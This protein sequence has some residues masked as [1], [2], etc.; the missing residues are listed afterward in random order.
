MA[1]NSN[2]SWTDHTWSPWRGCT[3][4]SAGC[5][6]CYA[7]ALAKRAGLPP[8][9]KGQPRTKTVPESWKK[10]LRWDKQ[11][12]K[13]KNNRGE[14]LTELRRNRG[15]VFV[16]NSNGSE[17][18]ITISGWDSLPQ[19]RPKVFFSLADP[20]DEEV[21]IE[22]L[23]DYLKLIHD[24]P[25]LDH[26]L[27]TKRPEN[28]QTRLLMAGMDMMGYVDGQRSTLPEALAGAKDDTIE[29]VLDWSKL[30]S[31]PTNVWLGVTAE[32]Q[33]MADKRI[34]ELLKIPAKVRF[35][36]CEPLLEPINLTRCA[37]YTIF[38]D[39][40]NPGYLNA[41]NGMC[42]H[43]ATC[44]TDWNEPGADGIN[45]VIAGGESGPKRREM[46]AQWM[47][48]LWQQCAGA[49]VPF[50]CKQDS[51]L[52]PGLQGRI[53]DEVWNTKEFPR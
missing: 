46:D 42:Y 23:A 25:N 26:L 5:A 49:A 34:P 36:S 52:R 28:I 13:Q 22:W 11:T 20:F 16:R 19:Y 35:L 12:T 8:Y 41:L 31:C 39:T 18:Y 15:D 7:E 17:G 21:P 30:E 43:P 14:I 9:A 27:L 2:I 53:P 1:E 44:Q 40:A 10:P 51:G 48:S 47:I 45:W 50:F 29:S 38:G 33:E 24:T 4:V 6:N 32:N 3:K 37:G